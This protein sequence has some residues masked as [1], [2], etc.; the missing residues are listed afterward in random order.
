MTTEPQPGM[1]SCPVCQ[2]V[3][4]EDERFCEACGHRLAEEPAIMADD[5]EELGSP[6]VPAAPETVQ[7]LEIDDDAV[8]AVSDRG[9]HHVRNEDAMA[10]VAAGG[11]VAVVL[12][13]GV[14]STASPHR[15]AQAAAQAAIAVLEHLLTAPAWPTRH[16]LH[17]LLDEAFAA[18]QAA[19]AAVTDDG[20]GASDLSP[21]TTLV[22]A[23]AGPGRV[24]VGNLGDSRAY[25]LS[26]SGDEG[27]LLTVDDSTA[28]VLMAE[29][30]PEAE[31]YARPGA[32]EIT[33]WL[34]ADADSTEPRITDLD[35]TQPGVVVVCTDGLWN[36]FERPEQLVRL[37][38]DAGRVRPVA[39]ARRLT[40][41]ALDA[42]GRDN[43]TVAVV[44]VRRAEPPPGP[45]PLTEE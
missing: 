33:R 18:A 6:V 38:V 2:T 29:G 25:W 32:H 19:A 26:G 22:A 20:A 44:P 43:I 30:V 28:Q 31:A 37:V 4:F 35:V 17:G 21:S 41:A 15:A 40:R 7:R 10:A 39:I 9:W 23:L 1:G 24:V 11:R 8:G 27:R 45:T 5:E 3:V 42:G 16:E 13:D 34:G 12:A 36:Y 14:G